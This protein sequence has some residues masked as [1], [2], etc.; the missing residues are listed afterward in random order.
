VSF[1]FLVVDSVTGKSSGLTVAPFSNGGTGQTTQQSAIDALT[2]VQSSGKYLRSDGTNATLSTIQSGDVPT[3]N[4]NTSGSAASFTG[5]LVGDVTG[6]QGATVVGKI[7]GV[8]L[9]GLATGI[10]K[11]T[12]STG[13]PSIAIAAD[14]PTLNQNTTG[15]AAN[16][17]ATTNSTITTLSSLS[18]PASQVSGSISG[19]A[20]NVTGTVAIAN[21]GTG[22]TTKQLGMDAL[23]PLT[24]KGDLLVLDTHTDRLSVGANG[25]VLTAD[26]TVFGGVKWAAVAVAPVVGSSLSL[27]ASGTI[28]ITLTDTLQIY[29]AQGASAS[30][31]ISTTPF[32][33]SAPTNGTYVEVVGNDDTN[34]VVFTFSD[35]AKGCVG[36]F[37]SIELF[38]YQ[39][40]GFRYNSSF[41]RWVLCSRV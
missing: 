15:T 20:A 1:K 18:L 31:T 40:A 14:F 13:V 11:N 29:R 28:T 23:S 39:V 24:T 9:S 33:T 5:S 32:G 27:A 6:T 21:G 4:Q 34:T 25:T 35:T 3:L 37:T 17:T 16:V 12:T 2:G 10:L 26:S 8:A 36:N 22:Q 30:V 19:S 38:K 7:N 41:D